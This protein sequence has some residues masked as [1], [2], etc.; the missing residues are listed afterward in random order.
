MKFSDYNVFTLNKDSLYI[1]NTLHGNFAKIN[2]DAD[3]IYSAMKGDGKIPKCHLEF[4]IK[5]NFVIENNVNEYEEC[6]K[7]SQRLIKNDDLLNLIILPTER[8]NFNCTYCYEYHDGEILKDEY[9]DLVVDFVEHHIEGKK[10]L[11]VSWFGGEP[12]INLAMVRRLSLKLLELC[13]SHKIS[14]SANMTTNGYLLDLETVKEL[15]KLHIYR[16]Q[17]TVDGFSKTHDKQRILIGGGNTWNK[18]IN[19]LED[20]RDNIH[21]GVMQYTIRTNVCRE[22]YEEY[23]EFID[24]L[25][26]HFGQDARFR[27]L[28]RKVSDWG[29]ID[30]S[31]KG[32]FISDL[33]YEEI[34]QYA[35]DKGM[36]NV[37]MQIA[38]TPGGNLCYAWKDNCYVIRANGNIGKCTI[39][40]DDDINQLGHISQTEI[41]NKFWIHDI[42]NAPESCKGCRKYP[43]CL[44]VKCKM[45]ESVK[46]DNIVKNI[47]KYL[48]LIADKKYGCI[49]YGGIEE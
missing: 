6:T 22:I 45:P 38:I 4:M 24:F 25:D 23:K 15:R 49:H 12:L 3:E 1:L 14:Y 30:D 9:V 47:E 43:I 18:I 31:V 5:N 36:F 20:I 35:L 44:K 32:T 10:G 46:C 21:S 39:L 19:N 42:K 41:Y 16:Y 29:N 11:N 13:H 37:A 7:F 33:E 2:V 26:N 17:I 40:I 27:F 28:I 34:L 48:P 8:C